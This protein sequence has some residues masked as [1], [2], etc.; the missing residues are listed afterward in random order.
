[1]TNEERDKL[2][3]NQV[4]TCYDN[5]TRIYINFMCK[6]GCKFYD[7][8]CTKNRVVRE[9]AKKGLKNVD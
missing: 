1:M 4:N 2:K 8:R 6:K 7:G 5:E 9:C 3:R